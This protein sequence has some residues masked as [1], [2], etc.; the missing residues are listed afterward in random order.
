MRDVISYTGRPHIG[1]D[2]ALFCVFLDD[3]GYSACVVDGD[4]VSIRWD[5]RRCIHW[6]RIMFGMLCDAYRNHVRWCR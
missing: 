2:P 1:I 5:D 3:C 6:S 4:R